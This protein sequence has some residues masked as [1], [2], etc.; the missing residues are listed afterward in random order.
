M[1]LSDKYDL[2][3]IKQRFPKGWSVPDVNG[4]NAFESNNLVNAKNEVAGVDTNHGWKLHADLKAELTA[5][6]AYAKLGLELKDPSKGGMGGSRIVDKDLFENFYQRVKALGVDFENTDTT[7]GT[8]RW[9]SK[10]MLKGGYDQA[11]KVAKFVDPND[12][13]SLVE[14]AGE[15]DIGFK[16]GSSYGEGRQFTFYAQ[17]IEERDRVIGVIEGSNIADRLED[18]Y[19]LNYRKKITDWVELKNAPISQKTSGRFTTDYLNVDHVDDNGRPFL[20]LSEQ[21]S[22][23]T[24]DDRPRNRATPAQVAENKKLIITGALNKKD[25]EAVE[26]VKKN[27]PEMSELLSGKPG[28]I[29]PYATIEDQIAWREANGIIGRQVGGIDGLH[30]R[31]ANLPPAPTPTPAPAP[32]PSPAPVAAPTPAPTA[33]T[34]PSV[35]TLGPSDKPY[36]GPRP[37]WLDKPSV[38][39][40]PQQ[41][42]LPAHLTAPTPAPTPATAP[43]PAAPS[44]ATVTPRNQKPIGQPVQAAAPTP[45]PT[46]APTPTTKP[47]GK[48]VISVGTPPPPPTG[49]GAQKVSAQVTQTGNATPPPA[50][51][52]TVQNTPPPPAKV[53]TSGAPTPRPILKKTGDDISKALLGGTKGT[54]NIK[55][56]GAAALLGLGAFAVSRNARPSSDEYERKL[57]MQRRGMM[58]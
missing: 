25:I 24:I 12:T 36:T 42:T 47:V 2:D 44:S 10:F 27:F 58:M 50:P 57:E 4:S 40:M 8:K 23:G 19:D 46:S 7:G 39:D 29:S 6:E 16:T 30:N 45:A 28:Y 18:Q 53:V 38:P 49:A 31:L 32:A 35:R 20:D 37:S 52:A 26:Q 41:P 56:A 1:N 55:L 9:L 34:S 5:E 3:E 21:S 51:R 54:R 13:L 15:N 33:T 22:Q 17:S 14:L 43:A 48:P 11:D